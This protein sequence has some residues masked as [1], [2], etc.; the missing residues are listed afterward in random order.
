MHMDDC[1][2]DGEGCDTLDHS[3]QSPA[4]FE[5][6][7]RLC[8][9]GLCEPLRARTS[10]TPSQGLLKRTFQTG[11]L[12]STATHACWCQSGINFSPKENFLSATCG[13]HIH[14]LE[15]HTIASPRISMPLRHMKG[16]CNRCCALELGAY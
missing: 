10:N 5:R 13:R 12:T 7:N 3:A 16:V 9:S 14:S 2:R 4:A 15:S 11:P 8:T 6:K 1:S